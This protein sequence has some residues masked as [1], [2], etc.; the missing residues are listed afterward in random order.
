MSNT[1]NLKSGS[2]HGDVGCIKSSALQFFKVVKQTHAVV[3]LDYGFWCFKYD[4]NFIRS[5]ATCCEAGA[6]FDAR[7][8]GNTSSDRRQG[9]DSLSQQRR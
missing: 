6:I 2:S 9:S 7:W 8:K 3:S 4:Q 5:F 1:A